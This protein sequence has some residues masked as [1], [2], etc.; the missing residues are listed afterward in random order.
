ME[1]ILVLDGKGRILERKAVVAV[2]SN[3]GKCGSAHEMEIVRANLV[4][5]LLVLLVLVVL[6]LVVVVV[7]V[8]VLVRMLLLLL[9]LLL[10]V[11]PVFTTIKR[12]LGRVL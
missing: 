12:R 4:L 6:M 1:R 8:L 10:V 11:R 7:L 2:V 5:T 3:V 9:L